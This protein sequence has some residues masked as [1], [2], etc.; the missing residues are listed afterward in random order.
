[1]PLKV[2]DRVK[3]SDESPTYGVVTAVSGNNITWK[4]AYQEL[5]Q[6]PSSGLTV[7]TE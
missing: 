1:M 7:T 2:G 6:T 5:R 3:T 4:T